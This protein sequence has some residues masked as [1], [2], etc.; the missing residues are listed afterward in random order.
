[1]S[2]NVRYSVLPN[3]ELP[4]TSVTVEYR[5]LTTADR[6]LSCIEEDR[7]RVSVGRPSIL[8]NNNEEEDDDS[9]SDDEA[10]PT[11]N[12]LQEESRKEGGILITEKSKD[13]IRLFQQRSNDLIDQDIRDAVRDRKKQQDSVCET[14]GAPH[15]QTLTQSTERDLEKTL[16]KADLEEMLSQPIET[17]LDFGSK[18]KADSALSQS[19]THA[20]SSGETSPAPCRQRVNKTKSRGSSCVVAPVMADLP[21]V[22]VQPSKSCEEQEQVKSEFNI[23]WNSISPLS[24]IVVRPLSPIDCRMKGT[25]MSPSSPHVLKGSCMSPHVPVKNFYRRSMSDPDLHDRP[26]HGKWINKA[27]Q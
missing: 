4:K 23:Y 21:L 2:G 25:C 17:D 19:Q 11:L 27:D 9:Q 26:E 13:H 24:P 5:T 12:I 14:D 22:M 15:V 8:N 16:I 10:D 18:R 20:H 3:E 1:M 7:P 6:S